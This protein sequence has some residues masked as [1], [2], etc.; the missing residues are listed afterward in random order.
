MGG[1]AT[2]ETEGFSNVLLLAPDALDTGTGAAIAA[3]DPTYTTVVAIG[4]DRS[5][6]EFVGSWRASERA[7]PADWRFVAIDEFARGAAAARPRP[8]GGPRPP[9]PVRSVS[10]PGDVGAIRAALGAHL[11][12]IETDAL[13][14]FEVS[15][16]LEALGELGTF[17]L[18]RTLSVDI[19]RAGA[20]GFFVLDP[21]AYDR[22]TIRTLAL[23]CDVVGGLVPEGDG[24]SSLYA[25]HGGPAPTLPAIDRDRP[26]NEL[27][28][29]LVHPRRRRV[30]AALFSHA[31]PVTVRDLANDVAAAEADGPVED[32]SDDERSLVSL[33]LHH[34]HL[35]K[36]ADYGVVAYDTD[37]RLVELVGHTTNLDLYLALV[38][39]FD[40]STTV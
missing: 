37:R 23:V 8:T 21:T 33:D 1:G 36:L 24:W 9:T 15:S 26:V 31:G 2:G 39:E 18:L 4:R 16:V 30:L 34:L 17:A 6:D 12:S 3:E 22:S 11:D 14:W 32:V 19:E 13:V 20:T 40:L 5:P 27:V 10:D 7:E 35:P 29:L 38:E 28:G 25:I